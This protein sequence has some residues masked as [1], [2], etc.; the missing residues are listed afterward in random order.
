MKN[1]SRPSKSR[2][3]M[4]GVRAK[5]TFASLNFI[6]KLMN[7]RAIFSLLLNPNGIVNEFNSNFCANL[8]KAFPLACPGLSLPSHHH[9][10]NLSDLPTNVTHEQNAVCEDSLD[11]EPYAWTDERHTMSPEGHTRTEHLLWGQLYIRTL[12]LNTWRSQTEQIISLYPYPKLLIVTL[13][14]FP[15]YQS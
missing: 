11:V 14:P 4:K 13:K 8:L 5:R 3:W 10:I 2:P 7:R 12:R 6:L 1:T 15:S 9:P